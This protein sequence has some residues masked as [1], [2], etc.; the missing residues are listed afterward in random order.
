MASSKQDFEQFVR[1][2]HQPEKTT[3]SPVRRLANLALSN[4]DELSQT[5]RHR[6]RRSIYLVEIMRGAL[7]MT[8]DNEP[9]IAHENEDSTW[10]WA[11]LNSITLGPFRGFRTPEPFDLSKQ[12][13]LFY[14]P[15]GSGKTSLC[16]GLEYALLGEVEEAGSK[17]IDANT[18][19]K[20]IIENRFEVPQL[21]AINHEGEQ[22]NV[23]SNPES[24]RFCFVERNRIDSFSRMAARPSGQRAELIATLFGMDQFS[25]FVSHFNESIDGQLVLTNE[26]QTTLT[27]RRATLTADQELVANEVA[28]LANLSKEEETLALTYN[29]ETTYESLKLL[30][31]SD[32]KPSRIH[33]LNQLIETIP[34]AQ[35]GLTLPQISDELNSVQTLSDSLDEITTTLHKMSDQVSY[36]ALYNSILELQEITGDR[37]PAC[38]TPLLGESSVRENPFEKATSGLEQLQEL[39][40]LQERKDEKQIAL[41]QASRTLRN[42]LKAVHT[43]LNGESEGFAHL[44]QYL[45]QLP[46]EPTDIWWLDIYPKTDKARLNNAHLSQ[47]YSIVELISQQDEKSQLAEQQRQI[48]IEERQKLIQYQLLVQAQDLKRERL[49]DEL[50]AAK[51]RI[52]EFD[53]ANTDL[54][55][56]A[57][58]EKANIE[59]DRTYKTCYDQFLEA[60]KVYR[61]ELPAQLMEGLNETTMELYNSFNRSDREEDKLAALHLPIDGNGKIEICFKGNP[62]NSVDAL[63]VLSEGHIRC[64]GLA[65][66]LAKAKSI[67]CP[68]IVFD[69]AINAIDHDHRG[70]I[71]ETIFEGDNFEEHQLIV[72]C[73]SN[74]FIKDIQQHL[75]VQKRNDCKVYVLRHHNGNYQP[76]VVGNIPSAN[77]ITKARAA[78]DVLNDRDA[79]SASRQALEMVSEKVWRWLGSHG[80]GVLKLMIVGAGAEPALRDLCNAIC[81]N[82]REARTFIHPNKAPL[83]TAYTH[84]LGIPENNLVWTYLNKGTHEEADRDDFDSEEV[85][86]VVKTLEDIDRLDLRPN[87]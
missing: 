2:L 17:R 65:I 77:Y 23:V 43:F 28:L 52:D 50:Q 24:Y 44:K 49:L 27:A 16:E 63:H 68:V 20:N 19:L 81:K 45:E 13:T 21:T 58:Q 41:E 87:R 26:H 18:Y 46:D 32:E 74:E 84:I 60:L 56:L 11:K 7:E 69:D 62:E 3:P 10:S 80:H 47:L 82:L 30:I 48:H 53:E 22:V 31:G 29:D 76:R 15:N 83:I 85:E 59:R 71:R 39:I 42:T 75:P 36:K 70:G 9:V 86:K 78:K 66:L 55:A 34:P 54:I 73:H 64:L 57:E 79:L 14:G 12:I 38:N 5:T 25:D 72:T 61:S 6:S 40:V 4:F 51:R 8:D 1:W 33:E 35:I 67:G 37:C